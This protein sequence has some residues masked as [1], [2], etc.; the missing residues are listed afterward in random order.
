MIICRYVLGVSRRILQDLAKL[1]RWLETRGP[2]LRNETDDRNT[3]R[4]VLLSSREYFRRSSTFLDF[5]A[6]LTRLRTLSFKRK[7]PRLVVEANSTLPGLQKGPCPD[8]NRGP[9]PA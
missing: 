9:L 6:A 4:E 7:S 3:R 5:V 8:L 1:G 2:K